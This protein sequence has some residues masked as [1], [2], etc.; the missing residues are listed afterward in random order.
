[1]LPFWPGSNAKPPV[2][3]YFTLDGV[4]YTLSKSIKMVS[5]ELYAIENA[6]NVTLAD[7]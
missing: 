4:V 1:M 5:E 7:S 2:F 3:K 6:G